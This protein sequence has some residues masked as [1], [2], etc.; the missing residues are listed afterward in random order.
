[1]RK[2]LGLMLT[3]LLLFSL[4]STSV[5]AADATPLL[6]ADVPLSDSQLEGATTPT[7]TTE[8]AKSVTDNTYRTEKGGLHVD[9]AFLEDDTSITNYIPEF[10]LLL[11]TK[12]GK[13]LGTVK[14][15]PQNYI[16]EKQKYSFVFNTDYTLG[17]EFQLYLS[18]LD[19]VMT[20]LTF[21]QTN[22]KDGKLVTETATLTKDK[23]Y[24]IKVGSF[25]NEDP[26]DTSKQVLDL[27]YTS[28]KPLTGGIYTDNKKVGIL[29]KTPKGD[30]IKN[31]NF[32]AK[33]IE[34]QG[35]KL[36]L[37]TNSS[38]IAWVNRS[39]LTH[40]IMISA[41]G[42]LNPDDKTLSYV[43]T[44]LPVLP[45]GTNFTN[46]SVLPVIL[47]Q[48]ANAGSVTV[49]VTSSG[50][51]DLSNYW[52][53]ANIT[54]TAKDA[55]L[56]T[57]SIPSKGISLT[58]VPDGDYTV[59]AEGKYANVS[60]ATS[61]L[62]VKNGI[63]KISLS[64][65]P[66]YTLEVDKDGK[67]YKFSVS[68][69][70]PSDPK[71]YSGTKA[72]I[73]AVTPGEVYT[74]KDLATGT[75]TTVSIDSSSQVTRVVLGSGVVFGGSAT[76]PHTGDSLPFLLG[77]LAFALLGGVLSFFLYMNN[78][79]KLRLKSSL[80][81]LILL[82]TLV[83]QVLTPSVNTAYATAESES[84]YY[85]TDS[86]IGSG[87][88]ADIDSGTTT[89]TGVIQTAETI[90]VLQI[91]FI[92]V[93]KNAQGDLLL[94][95]N[96]TLDD[97]KDPFKFSLANMRTMFYMATNT[98]NNT[99]LTNPKSALLT[100]NTN[101][102]YPLNSSIYGTNPLVADDPSAEPRK[103]FDDRILEPADKVLSRPQAVN[104]FEHFAAATIYYLRN[105]HNADLDK[106]QLWEG[107][108]SSSVANYG[109]VLS[110]AWQELKFGEGA[111][112]DEGGIPEYSKAFFKSYTA[113]LRDKLKM[114]DY[115]TELEQAYE[116]NEIVLFTQVVPAFYVKDHKEYGYA[117][118][119][120]HDAVEWYRWGRE[121]ANAAKYG[122]DVLPPTEEAQI[123]YGN[124]SKIVGHPAS[125]VAKIAP[126]ST[127]ITN[128]SN[129]TAKAI[130]PKSPEVM[131]LPEP[132]SAEGLRVNPFLG[133]GYL[134][135]NAA[136]TVA[137]KP[138]M[139]IVANVELL[140]ES[141]A[142]VETIQRPLNGWAEEQQAL[143]DIPEDTISVSSGMQFT[144]KRDIYNIVPNT[145]AKFTLKDFTDDEDINKVWD[146]V[147]GEEA[148]K[149]RNSTIAVPSSVGGTEWEI[150]FGDD[151]PRSVDLNAY[152]GGDNKFSPVVNKF[153]GTREFSNAILSIN[154][155]AV[156][157]GITPAPSSFEVPQWRLSKYWD[158]ATDTVTNSTNFALTLPGQS[159]EDSTLSPTH[160]TFS[161]IDPEVSSA[162]WALSKAKLFEDTQN[163][164]FSVNS[165]YARFNLAGDLLAIK[166]NS[167]VSNNKLASWVNDLPLYG[168][169]IAS[170]SKGEIGDSSSKTK[171]YTFRY[172]VLSPT[173]VYSYSETR[174]SDGVPY[175]W[176]GT[177]SI[178]YKTTDY[179]TNVDF[180]RYLP[181]D[182]VTPKSFS[183]EKESV[184]SKYWEA[185]QEPTTLNI[186]PEVLMASD[187]Q[188][189]G[190]SF[191][192][193]AAD[194][195]RPIKPITYNTAEYVNLAI[196]PEVTG[197]STATD[198][199]AQTLATR[200]GSNNKQVI[201]KGSAITTNFK[202]VGQLELKTFAVDIG[203]SPL[204]NNWNPAT[205]Y[206]TDAINEA[207]LDRHADKDAATGK[208]IVT[209][210]AEGK[211]K[212]GDDNAVGTKEYG[213][214]KQKLK[215][216]Q[217]SATSIPHALEIRGGKLIGVDGNRDLSSLSQELK[218]A[219]SRMK[220]SGVDNIF[221]TF[222]SG[223]GAKLTEPNF[224]RDGNSMRG[225]KDLAVGTGWYSED[226]TVIIV[227]EYINT[228]TLPFFAY[229]D[230]VPME[231]E[232][233][234]VQGDKT[235][236]FSEGKKGYV[237][238]D[239]RINDAWLKTDTSKT[240]YGV[241][242]TVNFIVPNVSILDS[243]SSQ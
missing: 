113:L 36:D 238:L 89:P 3:M 192:F 102:G 38:G 75:T 213:G 99:I 78:R 171:N 1:M 124:T 153:K 90:S 91:G 11:R 219:L 76:N 204:K 214:Q 164:S 46:A 155:K 161:L 134:P 202:T 117:F 98:E 68:N 150:I 7:S 71:V 174:Y 208:W 47:K 80:L 148:S 232:G 97:F 31:T 49:S 96:S 88:G 64:V 87:A 72:T 243:F 115:A 120:F 5:F 183:P 111:I 21:V 92:K 203:S 227:R 125:A 242:K 138:K 165:P 179:I 14:A 206:S 140:N 223:T 28:L 52:S 41:D 105:S 18:E 176:Y 128:V 108:K 82:L 188:G 215:A 112:V 2:I 6:Y 133:W 224:A 16:K 199:A 166:D 50:N 118:M 79:K 58:G 65:T 132:N 86:N 236:F 25:S 114:S 190:T 32:T 212:I 106:I 107:T 54:L 231:V 35:K 129:T 55:S 29:L 221:N 142:T 207:F 109:D 59:S 180:Q 24:N 239:F 69:F 156:K 169:K 136:N 48:D 189:G 195:L 160:G 139:R 181:K 145:A 39:T 4:F 74:L 235:K 240:G 191:V 15:G 100:F 66:K 226:T 163:K 10:S 141:G 211:M 218:D 67:S 77:V 154:L 81:S 241:T 43:M 147:T 193:A 116:Q 60:L 103:G 146:T 20:K 162:P 210:D 127:F 220:I 27:Q 44:S 222:E 175:T 131:I 8:V 158:K 151:I 22:F 187:N 19:S 40:D 184:N 104:D 186:N 17:S 185:T 209:L 26:K 234:K 157:D 23:F 178:D 143:V 57:F 101:Y 13:Y 30:V 56:Y 159:W 83:T 70:K 217:A 61:T 182:S 205:T 84:T 167:S 121:Q 198:K 230:K 229:V 62:S 73:F 196:D 137:N 173:S 168:G 237:V 172:G 201:Y 37:K 9:V 110:Q 200:L 126:V 33:M 130:K 93:P 95:T 233:L 170:T 123:V 122:K 12:E 119:P 194:K 135:L 45:D 42:Y 144:Y 216:V 228:F 94:R 225:A 149:A 51:T 63:G 53:D 197:L 34:Y 152:L 85:D 177:A